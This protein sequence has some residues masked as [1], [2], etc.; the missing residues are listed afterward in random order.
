MHT[1]IGGSRAEKLVLETI[2]R[3]LSRRAAHERCDNPCAKEP[4]PTEPHDSSSRSARS[5]SKRLNCVSVLRRSQVGHCGRFVS[6]LS[7]AGVTSGA[8][9]LV[10]NSD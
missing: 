9:F 2:L 7:W 10:R 4:D 3:G 1:G 6:R 8:G 5:V